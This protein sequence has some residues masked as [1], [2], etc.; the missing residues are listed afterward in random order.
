[1]DRKKCG[2]LVLHDKAELQEKLHHLCQTVDP[3][4]F[5]LQF[6]DL[7][8]N[9][10]PF[11]SEYIIDNTRLVLLSLSQDP[12][13]PDNFLL[14]FLNWPHP[15][16]V[17][18][19]SSKETQ[20]CSHWI[21]AGAKDCLS[22]D[23]LTQ[24]SL[25]RLLLRHRTQHEKEAILLEQQREFTDCARLSLMGELAG[26]I[27]HELAN[28]LMLLEG[29]FENLKNLLGGDDQASEAT[30]MAI[31]KMDRS[32]HR[33]D[34]IISSLRRLVQSATTG[35]FESISASDIIEE[36][37]EYAAPK[38]STS[39]VQLQLD[40]IPEDLSLD[41]RPIE[42]SQALLN[43][44]DNAIDAAQT[45]PHPVIQIACKSIGNQVEFAISDNGPG[46][47]D[48]I[49][50]RIKYPYKTTKEGSHSLG[51]GLRLVDRI[52]IAHQGTLY[53]N[54]ESPMTQFV[55]R[56]PQTHSLK[57]E[58]KDQFRVLIVDDEPGIRE[59][60]SHEFIAQG[61]HV[62][63]AKNSQQALEYFKS[64]EIDAVVADIHMPGE[65]GIELFEQI[66]QT[67]K[68]PLI[69]FM[70]GYIPTHFP[71]FHKIAD[72][73]IFHKPFNPQQLVN[74][75]ILNIRAHRENLAVP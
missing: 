57:N 70:T 44:I 36:T 72:F 46:V 1:M 7:R 22:T 9:S 31:H 4:Q 43:L 39:G 60:V 17:I 29:H 55:I 27:A 67:R 65:T 3:E 47:P 8:E 41:C 63:G 40:S 13:N 56:L 37:I 34:G 45:Q 51:L 58:V 28:P 6:L 66:H 14:E 30:F 73:P 38:I 24:E 23:S 11:T 68:N 10:F 54:E 21:G 52:A 75:V 32:L 49:K 5:E 59:I 62:I 18:V 20:T 35:E 26:G 12:P 16:S 25:S 53:V 42:I 33:I 19:I 48:T 74:Q 50:S 69:Y 71:N 64:K 61:C 15:P 2:V